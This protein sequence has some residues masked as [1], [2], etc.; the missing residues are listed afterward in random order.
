MNEKI[1]NNAFALSKIQPIDTRPPSVKVKQ[2]RNKIKAMHP[3]CHLINGALNEDLLYKSIAIVNPGA[4]MNEFFKSL[5]EAFVDPEISKM[6]TNWVKDNTYHNS[7]GSYIK[8]VLKEGPHWTDQCVYQLAARI[9]D[10]CID[11]RLVIQNNKLEYIG[12]K[13]GTY[14]AHCKDKKCITFYIYDFDQNND[15]S[16]CVAVAVWYDKTNQMKPKY[17]QVPYC[18]GPLQEDEKAVLSLPPTVANKM[19]WPADFYTKAV[20]LRAYYFYE[21]L[22][23]NGTIK[24]IPWFRIFFNIITKNISRNALKNLPN[25]PN[26]ALFQ[27]IKGK[28]VKG[29][30]FTKGWLH[31]SI[32]IKMNAVT[33]PT[34]FNIPGQGK[35]P[36]I[37]EYVQV[38]AYRIICMMSFKK[39]NTFKRDIT[40]VLH[41]LLMDD[42]HVVRNTAARDELEEEIKKNNEECKAEEDKDTARIIVLD[43]NKVQN[44]MKKW[45]FTKMNSERATY[46]DITEVK[47]AQFYQIVRVAVFRL[48]LPINYLICT[49]QSMMC[50]DQG[51]FDCYTAYHLSN[52]I[53]K[54]KR[55]GDRKTW[56]HSPSV[57]Y[58]FCTGRSF[59]G[60]GL[61]IIPSGKTDKETGKVG[62]DFST[63]FLNQLKTVGLK[64]ENDIA[65]GLNFLP[66]YNG[67]EQIHNMKKD[68]K[69]FEGFRNAI[70]TTDEW[71]YYKHPEFTDELLFYNIITATQPSKYS[72]AVGV[73]DMQAQHD[74]KTHLGRM[75]Q[76]WLNDKANEDKQKT[77]TGNLKCAPYYENCKMLY[78]I[79][80][81]MYNSNVKH[82]NIL[83]DNLD[84]NNNNNNNN[85]NNLISPVIQ[86]PSVSSK[87]KKRT[88]FDTTFRKS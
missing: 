6:L 4:D 32:A 8:E 55:Q 44:F 68:A 1:L 37:P 70:L 5:K 30:T 15:D 62:V 63:Q 42:F 9:V 74:I 51:K 17:K 45:N 43:H 27:S 3:N 31:Q 85:N 2:F 39:K 69:R 54:K 22:Q 19:K 53:G 25:K 88:S 12:Q 23:K 77:L 64:E 73:L 59:M 76:N 18:H 66:S 57:I 36:H 80:Q 75:Q 83:M 34:A 52:A 16:D 58:D 28:L 61:G 20:L 87:K 38:E 48:M 21:K 29:E 35:N 33:K 56:T 24:K 40:R 10:T 50:L 7:L 49:D 71:H 84:D 65:Y 14:N 11:V 78:D 47:A 79:Y 60:P 81:R 82:G 46:Y 72:G 13:W 41:A 26:R 86:K 67:W